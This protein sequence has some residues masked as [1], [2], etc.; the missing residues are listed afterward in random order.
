[1]RMTHIWIE[2][3]KGLQRVNTS[4][5]SFVCLIGENN[6]GKSSALQAMSAFVRGT[7]LAKAAYYDDKKEIR[8][9]VQFDGIADADF[10]FVDEIHRD[11]VRDMVRDGRL[12]DD[13]I[14]KSGVI[15][16][17][18]DRDVAARFRDALLSAL[19]Q[20]DDPAATIAL[21]V[22]L[23]EDALATCGDWI[24][25]LL[26]ERAARDA[27][28]LTWRPA[29]IRGFMRDYE[30]DPTSDRDLFRIVVNRLD[31]I[32]HDIEESDNSLREEVPK[33]STEYVLRRFVARKL[34]ERSRRRYTVPQEEEV[35][36]E[37][38]PDIRVENPSTAP[39]SIEIKWADNWTLKELLERLENQLIGQYLRDHHSRYGVYL[40]GMQGTKQHWDD[41]DGNRVGFEEVAAKVVQ[42][43]QELAASHVGVERLHVVTLDFCDPRNS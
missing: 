31:G 29:D 4:L 36:Q 17:T 8:I 24:R 19:S 40:L 28:I 7:T 41:L 27:D 32:R 22:L 1:M 13:P 15:Y 16:H 11:R 3:F 38:R 12:A 43:A 33:G 25:H 30:I 14:R 35:D 39:V 21:K 23:A 9:Q 10:E 6:A 42:R 2:N 26:D 20:S 5:S 34:T 37:Q 18:T